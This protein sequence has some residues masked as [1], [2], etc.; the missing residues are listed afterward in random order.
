MR[1][2][3][4]VLR[5][6]GAARPSSGPIAAA[7]AVCCRAPCVFPCCRSPASRPLLLA[8]LTLPLHHLPAAALVSL[9]L[10][11]AY[12]TRA[13]ITLKDSSILD[14]EVGSGLYYTIRFFPLAECRAASCTPA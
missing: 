6:L 14:P 4:G 8:R 10:F 13:G 3:Q 12:V 2:H 1:T 9:A 7:R 11:G 5:A